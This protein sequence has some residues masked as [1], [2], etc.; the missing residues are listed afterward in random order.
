MG[1]ELVTGPQLHERVIQRGVLEATRFVWIA[2]ANLK[3]M[4]VRMVRTYRPILEVFDRMAER[5]VTFRIVHSDLPSG[6]FR[7]TLEKFPRLY[8]QAIELQICPRSHWKMVIV[9]QRLAYWG[10][11]NFTGA[12]LGAKAEHRRNLEMGMVSEDPEWVHRITGLFDAF[13]MGTYCREC[14]MRNRCPDP[15]E[16]G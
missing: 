15:I 7:E 8:R 1:V 4:R 9:D 11:A 16:T 14:N 12:G 3:D 2:T 6:P 10:S 5:G 13:W